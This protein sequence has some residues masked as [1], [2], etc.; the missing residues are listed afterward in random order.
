MQRTRGQPFDL[1]VLDFPDRSIPPNRIVPEH[2]RTPKGPARRV[3]TEMEIP[4]CGLLTWCDAELTGT[5]LYH[6]IGDPLQMRGGFYPLRSGLD[7][8]PFPQKVKDVMGNE[9]FRILVW[10]GRD[11]VEDKVVALTIVLAHELAH[12]EQFLYQPQIHYAGNFILA[13]LRRLPDAE[14]QRYTYFDSPVEWDAEARA[15]QVASVLHGEGLVH[16]YMGDKRI[17]AFTKPQPVQSLPEV[18]AVVTRWLQEH[19]AGISAALRRAREPDPLIELA[20]RV[21]WGYFGLASPTNPQTDY[22]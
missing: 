15:R 7:E 5:E 18:V 3:F 19:V 4:E 6:A 21:N 9:L 16:N 8:C 1:G 22:V 14:R 12:V 17:I 10:L 2:P 11:V 13:Y 20:N